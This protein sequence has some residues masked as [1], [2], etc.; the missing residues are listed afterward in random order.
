MLTF[1][2]VLPCERRQR[3][4]AATGQTRKQG[5]IEFPMVPPMAAADYRR[6]CAAGLKVSIH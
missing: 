6:H 1:E 3:D 4:T 2:L 5:G